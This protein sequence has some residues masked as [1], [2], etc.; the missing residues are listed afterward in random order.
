MTTKRILCFGDS[1][2]HVYGA[3]ASL[4][5]V[6]LFDAGSVISTGGV[7]GTLLA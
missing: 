7:D 5:E 2:T 1:L 3:L 6:P 4:M